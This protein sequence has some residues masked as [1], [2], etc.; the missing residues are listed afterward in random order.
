M[1]AG[2]RFAEWLTRERYHPRSSKH[3]DALC[4]FLVED[5]LS[6]CQTMAQMAQVGRLVFK[7][8]YTINHESTVQW[9]TDLVMGPPIRESM[10]IKPGPLGIAEAQPSEIWVAIDAKTIMTEHGKA[11]RNRQRDLNAL[12]D[13]LHRRQPCPVVAGLIAINMAQRFRSPLRSEVTEHK[14]IQRLVQETLDIF[15]GLPRATEA[16]AQGLDA[17]GAIVLSFTNI[18]SESCSLLHSTPAPPPG[19]SV[20]YESLLRDLCGAFISRGFA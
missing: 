8:N 9:N 3:G 7:L 20:H 11:R 12:Q 17:M 1:T 2:E 14:N 13:L 19:D 4:K 18:G 6:S 15:R 5:L 16:G 10:S